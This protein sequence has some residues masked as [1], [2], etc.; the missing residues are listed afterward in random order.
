MPRPMQER[1]H[2]LHDRI[3]RA[4][5]HAE[6]C[7]AL[8]PLATAVAEVVEDGERFE[9][10]VLERLPHKDAVRRTQDREG[11]DP[12]L[13]HD[14]DLFVADVSAT[15]FCLLNKYPI[16]DDHVL[17]VTRAFAPQTDPLDADDFAALAWCLAQQD[18]VGFYNAGPEAGASQPHK[19]LQF[20]PGDRWRPVRNLGVASGELAVPAPTDPE[21]LLAAYRRLR[22]ELGFERRERPYNLLLTR[23]WM[24]LVPRTRAECEGIPVNALAFAGAMLARDRA[25][26]ARLRELGPRAVLRAVCEAA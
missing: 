16:L 2:A 5:A 6:R 9:V 12:F 24:L 25:Q 22:G 7:G 11:H 21:A 13:P 1:S 3:R 10:R 19:H 26:L 17:L 8:V 4:A 14:P 23:Q 18:G 15:H 20:V